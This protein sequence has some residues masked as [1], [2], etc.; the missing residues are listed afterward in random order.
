[1]A[2][3]HES[4]SCPN[5]TIRLPSPP[6]LVRTFRCDSRPLPSFLQ[7]LLVDWV[8]KAPAEHI[9][10]MAQILRN[11]QYSQNLEMKTQGQLWFEIQH[12]FRHSLFSQDDMYVDGRR[13]RN[14]LLKRL[15]AKTP[16]ILTS[17]C[18]TPCSLKR[19]FDLITPPA[20]KAKNLTISVLKS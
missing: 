19:T 16:H 14:M 18:A 15:R 9:D 13:V 3:F 2:T 10:R 17:P 11:I 4:Q 12:I 20:P 6:Q 8:Q 5:L 7:D 1:M